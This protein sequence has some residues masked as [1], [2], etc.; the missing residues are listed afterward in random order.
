MGRRSCSFPALKGLKEIQ[1]RQKAGGSK[2]QGRGQMDPEA[3]LD[4]RT[5]VGLPMQA[6]LTDFKRL[7]PHGPSHLEDLAPSPS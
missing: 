6:F 5:T 3:L 1:C 4:T 2:V 7:L